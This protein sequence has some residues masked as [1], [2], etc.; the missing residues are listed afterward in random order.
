MWIRT[1]NRI[2][3]ISDTLQNLAIDR[4]RKQAVGEQ[5]AS[6]CVAAAAGG[7]TPVISRPRTPRPKHRGRCAALC[8]AAHDV[9]RRSGPLGHTIA[10]GTLYVAQVTA[11]SAAGRTAP[12]PGTP[13]KPPQKACRGGTARAAATVVPT[14]VAWR[15]TCGAVLLVRLCRGFESP[16]ARRPSRNTCF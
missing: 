11:K 2:Q 1:H 4:R 14:P 16:A 6:R 12:R 9:V 10:Q 7:C 13:A 3:V 15:N 8:A 5:H